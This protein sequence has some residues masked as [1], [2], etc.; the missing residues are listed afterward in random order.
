MR[1]T[2]W[3]TKTYAVRVTVTIEVAATIEI[4][5]YSEQDALERAESQFETNLNISSHQFEDFNCHL[6]EISSEV[7]EE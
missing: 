3:K 6:Q 1:K 5:G 7:V 2:K 4:D